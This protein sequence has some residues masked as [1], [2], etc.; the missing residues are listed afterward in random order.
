MS[1]DQNQQNQQNQ[2]KQKGGGG[3]TQVGITLNRNMQAGN[4]LRDTVHTVVSEAVGYIAAAVVTTVVYEAMKQC[5]GG[6]F[7]GGNSN[8]PALPSPG[9]AA[10]ALS[11]GDP[12]QIKSLI[13]R[14]PKLLDA[15]REAVAQQEQQASGNPAPVQE[16][17]TQP[18]QPKPDKEQSSKGNSGKGDKNK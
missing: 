1:G 13:A 18:D 17:V 3:G 4:N 11:N 7:S 6:F 10:Y 12:N 9:Q 5:F 8:K 16:A 14:N 2:N 15:A